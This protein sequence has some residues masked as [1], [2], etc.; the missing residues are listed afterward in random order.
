MN[1]APSMNVVSS[2]SLYIHGPHSDYD[3]P[4]SHCFQPRNRLKIEQLM[5]H[6]FQASLGDINKTPSQSVGTGSLVLARGSG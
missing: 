4:G 2:S 3:T 6:D 1:V 5:L